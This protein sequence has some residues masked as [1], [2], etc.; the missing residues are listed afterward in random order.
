MPD[1]LEGEVAVIG[2][3]PFERRVMLADTS[4]GFW[5]LGGPR[6]LGELMNL[7]GHYVRVHG[8]L[9]RQPGSGVQ[10]QVDRYELLPVDGR[11]P[12]VGTVIIEG[13][14]PV[15]IVE[16]T[17]E[18]YVLGGPLD[19]ALRNFE[20]LKLW[21]LGDEEPEGEAGGGAADK[22]LNVVNYGILGP[23]SD[24]TSATSRGIP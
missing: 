22:R 9:V 24:V 6:L 17:G 14:R 21:I 11:L 8:T 20:G 18:W 10:M 3:D 19:H 12:L 15:L 13:G 2:V 4:G 23:A 16:G 7:A 5:T 1:I